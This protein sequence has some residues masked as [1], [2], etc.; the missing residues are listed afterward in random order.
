MHL[1]GYGLNLTDII[2]QYVKINNYICLNYNQSYLVSPKAAYW[3]LFYSS[4][5]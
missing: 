4:F 1:S 3:A 2:I 5:A